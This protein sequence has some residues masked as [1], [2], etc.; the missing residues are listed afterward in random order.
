MAKTI[1]INPGHGGS[2]PGAVSKNGNKESDIALKVCQILCKR[3]ELNWY[4]FIIYQQKRNYFE[5]SKK[6]N[7]SKSSVFI[8]VHCNSAANPEAHGIE[9]LYKTPRGKEFAKITLNELVKATGLASRGVKY[10]ENLHVL[11]RTKAPAILIELAFLSNPREEK[12]LIENPEKFANAI[13]EA[14]K[15]L[16]E[17]N[18]IS[19]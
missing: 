3:L 16:K 7:D 10:R 18:L 15:K 4:P 1:F 12:L 17:N 14:I 5:I 9:V 2:D 11:N 19:I 6:E 13:W 8:S